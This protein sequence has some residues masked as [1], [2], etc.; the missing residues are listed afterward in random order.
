M[1]LTREQK[2]F[3]KRPGFDDDQMYEVRIAFENG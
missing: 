1:K 3:I 2:K